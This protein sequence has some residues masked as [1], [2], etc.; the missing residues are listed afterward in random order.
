MTGVQQS[1]L[2]GPEGM[3]FEAAIE[4]TQTLL[5]QFQQGQIQEPS[6]AAA[7]ARLVTTENGA[8]GFFVVYLSSDHTVQAEALIAEALEP[9]LSIVAPLLVKN[10]AMSTAMAITHQRNQ[11]PDLRQGSERVQT[12]TEILIRLLDAPALQAQ[13]QGLADS[14]QTGQGA[15]QPFLD[16][17]GYDQEQRQAIYTS[18]EQSGLLEAS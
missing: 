17:W 15:Y 5:M 8:R 2:S 11:R 18:L 14:I 4:A 9:S 13:A 10:L 7:I 3:S 12:R 16:R 1:E 6:L